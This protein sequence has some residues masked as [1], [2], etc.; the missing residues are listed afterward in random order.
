M[1]YHDRDAQT[2]GCDVEMVLSAVQGSLQNGTATSIVYARIEV[3]QY[4]TIYTP[5]T[6]QGRQNI[7]QQQL[8]NQR[9]Y[10]RR[11]MRLKRRSDIVRPTSP[12]Q[13]AELAIR[14]TVST[15]SRRGRWDP[16]SRF[17]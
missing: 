11:V 17:N 12:L 5:A 4:T 13:R 6:L 2:T 9:P 15:H 16:T 1:S 7:V 10:R 14:R 3:E 8:I